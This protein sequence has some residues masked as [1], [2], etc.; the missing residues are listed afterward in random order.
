VGKK[1]KKKKKEALQA[2]IWLG[3]IDGRC[4]FMW[5]YY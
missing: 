5:G 3:E 1:K 2:S 4:L